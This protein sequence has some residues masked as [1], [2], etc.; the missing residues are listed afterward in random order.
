MI[1]SWAITAGPWFMVGLLILV[2]GLIWTAL[3]T[4]G[5]GGWWS[6]VGW[7][8]VVGISLQFVPLFVVL[9]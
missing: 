8:I 3:W 9:E 1:P 2:V 7:A 4:L 6:V 5:K